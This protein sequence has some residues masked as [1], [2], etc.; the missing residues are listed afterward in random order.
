MADI[1]SIKTPDGTVYEIKDTVA[2]SQGGGSSVTK[3]KTV[4]IS[5]NTTE[6]ILTIDTVSSLT[7][8]AISQVS[9]IKK[10][11]VVCTTNN[12]GGFPVRVDA[13]HI[14]FFILYN[15]SATSLS[16]IVTIDY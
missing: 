14:G 7:D 13:T 3:T 11:T 15:Q 8:A 16:F 10:L 1:S 5:G 4:T 6:N 9:A 12:A 2:R